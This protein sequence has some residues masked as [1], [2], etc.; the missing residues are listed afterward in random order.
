MKVV[1]RIGPCLVAT[2]LVMGC[3]NEQVYDS[4]QQHQRMECARL[5]QSQFERCM[6]DYS[7]SYRTYKRE[8]KERSATQSGP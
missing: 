6:Q 2:L 1:M 4:I 7:T 8:N 5:P 3:S